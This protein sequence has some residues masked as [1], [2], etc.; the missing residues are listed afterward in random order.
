[1][2][3]TRQQT[4]SHQVRLQSLRQK[5]AALQGKIEELEK[6]PS[7][8]VNAHV[9]RKLKAQKLNLKDKIL[10]QENHLDKDAVRH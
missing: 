9:L 5:H 7:V 10:E 2:S 6:S 3:Q 1:M 8:S 4:S